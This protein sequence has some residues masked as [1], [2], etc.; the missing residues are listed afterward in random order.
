[1]GNWKKKSRKALSVILV[2][3]L[4]AVIC[5]PKGS[6]SAE[7]ESGGIAYPPLLITEIVFDAKTATTATY[8]AESYEYFELHNNSNQPIPL[9]E[10]SVLYGYYDDRPPVKLDITDNKSLLPGETVVLWNW[11]ENSSDTL[12]KFNETYGTALTEENIVKLVPGYEFDNTGGRKLSIA[13]DAGDIVVTARYNDTGTFDSA[14]ESD[15]LDHTSVV[16][17]Y[18][19]DGSPL[20]VKAGSKQ[21]PTPGQILDGQVPAETVPMPGGGAGPYLLISEIVFNAKTAAGATGG[22]ESYEYVE[23]YNNSNR[24]VPMNEYQIVYGYWNNT[25]PI[26]LDITDDKV[27]QPGETVVIWNYVVNTSDTLAN[28][29]KVYG[30]SFTDDQIITLNPGSGFANTG[31]RNISIATDTGTVIATVIY[32]NANGYNANDASDSQD[33][34]GI[35]YKAAPD[36]SPAMVKLLT[37][38][39]PTPGRLLPEQIP[40]QAMTLPED[41]LKPL[42]SH[43]IPM[44]S[45]TPK[46]LAI[47]ASVRDDQQVAGVTLH[48]KNR[49]AAEYTAIPMKVGTEGQYSA[50]IPGTALENMSL[51]Q[52]YIEATDGTNTNRTPEEPEQNHEIQV[53]E[54]IGPVNLE[55]LITEL[56]P[57]N[58]GGDA[59]EY[60]EVYNNTNRKINLKDYRIVYAVRSG[61]T[62]VWD[63]D[64]DSVV[65]PQQTVLIWVQSTASK[66]KPISDF[67]NHHNV[68]LDASRIVP[69][70]ADG[71]NN[72]DEGRIM[73]A[74]DAAYP[75]SHVGD[76]VTQAWFSVSSDQASDDGKSIV[77]EY[78]KNG[79]NRMFQRAFGQIATPGTIINAQVP[80]QPV[81]I[82]ED[83]EKPVISHTPSSGEQPFADLKLEA[84]I[85]DNRKIKQVKLYYKQGGETNYRSVNMPRT[86]EANLY[87]SET[88]LQQN[89]LLANYVDYYFVASDGFQSRSTLD[90]NGGVPYRLNFIQD[91]RPLALNVQEGEYI[92]GTRIIQANSAAAGNSVQ[93]SVDGLALESQPTLPGDGYILFEADDMQSGSFKNGL[94]VN[95]EVVGFL[96]DG[97]AYS[98]KAVAIPMHKL[99]PGQNIITLAA[100]NG[101]SPT[102]QEGNNDDFRLQNVHI[103]LWNGSDQQISSARIKNANGTYTNVDPLERVTIGDGSASD[104]TAKQRIEYT[105]EIPAELF[106]GVYHTF[107]STKTADGEHTFLAESGSGDKVSVKA[108]VDNTAPAVE[109]MSL[110]DGKTYRGELT[111][112]AKVSDTG[113]GVDLTEATLDGEPIT[114]PFK[115]YGAEL[116]P[117]NHVFQVKAK[118]KA[119]NEA[120]RT[121]TFVLQ[122]ENP[123]KP[124]D[125][126]PA[127]NATGV[128]RNANLSV[129]VTD[130][131]GDPLNVTFYKA[132]QYDFTGKSVIKG[133]SNSTD[134]EPPLE[135]VPAGETEFTAEDKAKVMAND[136]KYLVTES[137]MKFPYHRFDFTVSHELAAADEVEI[138][139]EGHSLPDR[140]VT[141]YTW[142]HNTAKWEAAA[143]GMGAEDFQLKAK[144]NAG[145][146]VRNNVVNVLVQDLVPSPGD[147]D[148][149]FAW[150]SDTQYY[151]DSYPN[152]YETMMKYLV[153]EKEEKKI[154]YS[155]HTG[156]LVD[157]WDRPDEWA[158]ADKSMKYLDDAGMAYGVVAGNHDVNH[159]EADYKEYY[160]YFG[161]DR[162]EKQPTFGGDLNN[163]R[164]HY[165]LVSSNGHDF[166]IMYLGW[167]VEEDTIKWAND[168]LKKY[169]DRYAIIATHQY[170]SPSGAY[171]GDGEK[172]WTEVVA[173]NK[174]VYMVL[175][176]HHHGVAYNVKHVG[177]RTVVELLS[178]YQSGREGGQGYI[179]FLQF[180]LDNHKIHV[181]TYSP[182]MKD[183]N[184][185]DEPGKDEFDIEYPVRQVK[186]QVATDYIG[187]NVYT[188]AIIDSRKNAKSGSTAAAKWNKLA[189]NTTYYWYT[190]VTD[191]FGGKAVSDIWKFTTRR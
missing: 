1:M 107:D 88:V 96:P 124:S 99:K 167:D 72:A 177:E 84:S 191:L 6:V 176:G 183:E 118:D 129:K 48:Y 159:E 86:S 119:G 98:Q 128:S 121:V 104:A 113:S 63:I 76:I 40:A 74:A 123:M 7:G 164:D 141:L 23:V 109:G 46:D 14:N 8:S 152:I 122:D 18:A 114:I 136:G 187:V 61:G 117:G 33:Q 9:N 163:N 55:L 60:V 146:M 21:P 110:E 97:W 125:P 56:L 105:I 166:I 89:F 42:I 51:L 20:M 79:T 22:G 137:D 101:V 157:D 35:V 53:F 161:R 82:P 93:L 168:V 143:R 171:A 67:N 165:D 27:L 142:N 17:N 59:Y 11:L 112:D 154:I 151:S 94:L 172:I 148:F 47:T 127:A 92:R 37:K 43:T 156:D 73:I 57:D 138:V 80:D 75:V 64:T 106:Q 87:R 5:L 174:N 44:G 25:T 32:N 179:R 116:Q 178:D 131:N 126:Q 16:Y 83:T 58:R 153:E 103:V 170:I 158:V 24:P 181:N 41:F 173:P 77:Y 2:F 29:N 10:Y 102:A 115:Q 38:Q 85:T 190:S 135:L 13:T 62:T 65:E 78:P 26:K 69:I 175:C 49:E 188:K 81:D 184:Y 108:A 111:F 34:T 39:P 12:D 189:G 149:T 182:Y 66:N 145:D 134:R 180:D 155:I 28:F 30:T 160:K 144:V 130:P 36:G 19:Q 140:Q 52:Y 95:E 185:Y 186:K 169:P 139:W 45:T 68:N 4:L 54:S 150:V 31:G 71:M 50:V 120:I 147:V 100:G 15:D 133:F 3:A 90:D 162:F 132:Y 91:K 70:F